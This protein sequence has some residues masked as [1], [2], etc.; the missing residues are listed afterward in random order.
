MEQK[1]RQKWQT[2]EDELTEKLQAAQKR[3][4]D[5]QAQKDP[6]Q[7]LIL[8]PEQ[9]AAIANFKK[10]EAEIKKQLKAVRKSLRKEIDKL[11]LLLKVIN[12]A[13]MPFLVGIA[14]I[15]YGIRRKTAR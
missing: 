5:L 6:Q 10:E 1:A 4:N 15:V 14:G 12:I 11:G 3:L 9:K 7:R 13:A 2:S 8:S